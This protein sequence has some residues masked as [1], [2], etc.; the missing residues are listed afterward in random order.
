MYCYLQKYDNLTFLT[1]FYCIFLQ[2]S[3]I[4]NV[5]LLALQPLSEDKC[6]DNG[7]YSNSMTKC[8]ANGEYYAN[9][10]KEAFG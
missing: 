4:H 1:P 3:L 7:P 5:V 9:Q 8:S 2:N 6:L 10:E